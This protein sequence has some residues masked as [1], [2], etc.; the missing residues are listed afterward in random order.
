[1]PTG[2]VGLSV[3]SDVVGRQLLRP[4]DQDML[5]H[6]WAMPPL[7]RHRHGADRETFDIEG[8]RAPLPQHAPI[9]DHPR[10]AIF[11]AYGERGNDDVGHTAILLERGRVADQRHDLPLHRADAA[12]EIALEKARSVIA[13]GSSACIAGIAVSEQPV[14]D[15]VAR[16][17]RRRKNE[18]SA[19]GAKRR[20]LAVAVDQDVGACLRRRKSKAMRRLERDDGSR[21]VDKVTLGG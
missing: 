2:T 17:G 15:A 7:A 10:S 8:M 5:R 18:T 6:P 12:K 19:L 11:L 14:V 16:G 3:I 13:G 9:D 21:L 20:R 4:S 1:V